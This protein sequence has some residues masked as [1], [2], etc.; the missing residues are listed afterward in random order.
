MACSTYEFKMNKIIQLD[1][2][3]LF[4]GVD[5]NGSKNIIGLSFLV[6]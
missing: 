6:I 4:V 5:V 2:K 3:L 1:Q